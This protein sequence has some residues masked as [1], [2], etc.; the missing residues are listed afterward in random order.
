MV[1][2]FGPVFLIEEFLLVVVEGDF[3]H[4][5]DFWRFVDNLLIKFLSALLFLKTL[6]LCDLHSPWRQPR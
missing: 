4:V 2:P 6:D 3:S 1:D 5:M